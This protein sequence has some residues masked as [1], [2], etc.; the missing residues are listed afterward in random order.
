MTVAEE[1]LKKEGKGFGCD[2]EGDE[3]KGNESQAEKVRL[4]YSMKQ[5]ATVVKEQAF[6]VSDQIVTRDLH[7]DTT[8]RICVHFVE[9]SSWHP[10]HSPLRPALH[11][12]PLHTTVGIRGAAVSLH[13][14]GNT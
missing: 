2:T 10:T 8:E 14:K 5:K 3:E 6:L 9:V 11:V 12:S 13:V 1:K 7:L 4:F